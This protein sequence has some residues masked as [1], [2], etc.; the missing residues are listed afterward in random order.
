MRQFLILSLF[1]L[2]SCGT[3]YKI[4]NIQDKQKDEKVVVNPYFNQINKEYGYRFKITFLKKEMKG[5][6]VVKKIGENSHR[7]VLT[8]DFG[9]TLFDLSVTDSDFTLN[10]AMPDLNKKVIVKTLAED[11]QTIFKD[12]FSIDERIKTP[13]LIILK[14]D[15]VSLV[16]D[17]NQSDYFTELIDL[18]KNKIKTINKFT[19]NKSDFPDHILIKHNHFNLSIELSKVN[20]VL[21]EE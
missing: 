21:E 13:N 17:E 4:A 16:F 15:E 3:T 19:S 5:N 6:F 18:K 11:L 12:D 20:P 8:S 7:V 2:T 14:S 9:N 10:Y 1:I